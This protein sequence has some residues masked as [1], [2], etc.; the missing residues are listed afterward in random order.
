MRLFYTLLALSLLFMGAGNASA[1]AAQQQIRELAASADENGVVQGKDGWL[2]LKEELEHL[3]SSAFYGPDVLKITKA[4][5]PE[6]GDPLPAIVDF[7]NQLKERG[8]ELVFMPIPP[9]ALIYPDMLPGTVSAETA[10]ELE[11]PYKKLYTELSTQGV[12]VLDLIPLFRAG[13]AKEQ[14]YC[15]TDTHFSGSGLALVAETLSDKIQKTDWYKGVAK[16]EYLRK[17]GDLSIHG[18]LSA[19]Q[20][21]DALENVS[22]L[23][24]TDAATGKAELSDSDSPVLLLGDSHTLVFSVGGDLHSKGAGLFDHLSANLGFPVDL[25]GVRGSGATPG[26]IKLYQRSRKDPDYLDK[27]KIIVWGLSV[28]E[29]TG[30]GGWRKIP[31]AKK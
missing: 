19:M 30:I 10:A 8:I 17:P 3:G 7:N 16:K 14:L 15:K 5:K 13:R 12:Q 21:T 22:L 23:F 2:F 24:V 31:V 6:F 9:K 29:L 20:K 28:R 26:R 11:Q 4:S 25:L 27:K 18:D 1:G